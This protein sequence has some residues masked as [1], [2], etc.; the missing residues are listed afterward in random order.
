MEVSNST[1]PV[2]LEITRTDI[3]KSIR[4]IVI[5]SQALELLKPSVLV[6]YIVRRFRNRKVL[7]AISNKYTGFVFDFTGFNRYHPSLL[8]SWYTPL[9][10]PPKT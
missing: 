7:L 4:N 8:C 3:F 1:L 9:C 10:T 6:K 2:C 5:V